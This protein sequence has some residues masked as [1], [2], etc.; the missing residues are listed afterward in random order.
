LLVC[1]LDELSQ[2]RAARLIPVITISWPFWVLKLL[3]SWMILGA[4]LDWWGPLLRTVRQNVQK[5]SQPVWMIIGLRVG[6]MM[7]FVGWNA[8][9]WWG[10]VS[11]RRVIWR[12]CGWS[13]G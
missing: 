12:L 10:G 3:I 2:P 8:E 7:D 13:S 11:G 6:V 9:G 1:G 4:G 5:L